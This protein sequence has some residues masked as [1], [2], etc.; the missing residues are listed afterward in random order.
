MFTVD[1][2]NAHA[3]RI[4]RDG[5][6]TFPQPK[7]IQIEPTSGASKSY[8]PHCTILHR[9]ADDTGCCHSYT[10][11]C[12]PKRTATVDLYFYVSTE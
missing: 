1:K 7:I 9:C 6:C 12:V 5:P 4:Y 2:A 10:E 3:E 11:T 8:T